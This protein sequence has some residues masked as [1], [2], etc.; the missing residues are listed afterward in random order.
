MTE[1]LEECLLSRKLVV[2]VTER[3]TLKIEAAIILSLWLVISSLLS[4]IITLCGR[5]KAGNYII[6]HES[7]LLYHCPIR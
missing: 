2:K 7:A 3:F 6:F 1:W 5:S 4:L